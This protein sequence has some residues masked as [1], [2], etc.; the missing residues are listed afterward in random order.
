MRITHSHTSYWTKWIE[1]IYIMLATYTYEL[2]NASIWPERHSIVLNNSTIWTYSYY[3]MVGRYV[4]RYNGGQ[5]FIFRCW[6]FFINGCPNFPMSPPIIIWIN[7]MTIVPPFITPGI[8][9]NKTIFI[10]THNG[11]SMPTQWWTIAKRW[12]PHIFV[13][14]I[15]W[16]SNHARTRT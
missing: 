8:S 16:K 10:V 4:R 12:I 5:W 7:T 6:I 14:S 11:H 2:Q 1:T 15:D 13:C 9:N 3:G